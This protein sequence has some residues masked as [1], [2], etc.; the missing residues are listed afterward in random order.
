[1]PL[2][3]CTWDGPK[4]RHFKS[5]KSAYPQNETL[6]CSIL[7]LKNLEIDH[8]LHEVKHFGHNESLEYVE[9]IFNW[10]NEYHNRRDGSIR[11]KN[12]PQINTIA[13]QRIFPVVKNGKGHR[14]YNSLEDGKATSPWFISDRKEF[15]GSFMGKVPLVAFSWET[16]QKFKDLFAT[17]GLGNRIL[18]AS[19]KDSPVIDG[20]R[21]HHK[22]YTKLLRQKVD[23]MIR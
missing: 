19:A 8:L 11:D 16:N 21:V 6:F 12:A 22:P 20:F 1:M 13:R 23:F 14:G 7:R 4:L 10:L 5:I 9:Y 3:S 15:E 18:S 17:M 2:R